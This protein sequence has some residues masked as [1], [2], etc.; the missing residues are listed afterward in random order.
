[1]VRAVGEM[2]FM[3]RCKLRKRGK[4]ELCC[5]SNAIQTWPGPLSLQEEQSITPIV[6]VISRGSLRNVSVENLWVMSF[7]N[8]WSVPC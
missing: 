6:F 4:D 3:K 2:A 7:G 8:T 5:S 1:M